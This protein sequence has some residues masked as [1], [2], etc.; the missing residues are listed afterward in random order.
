MAWLLV[1]ARYLA[2]G[3]DFSRHLHFVPISIILLSMTKEIPTPKELIAAAIRAGWRVRDG[4]KHVI[5]YPPDG[6]RPVVL[7]RQLKG[8]Q[9]PDQVKK[10]RAAG[11]SV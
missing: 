1:L 2:H 6:Q 8:R 5:I 10:C 11:L 9:I 4:G 3:Q 7:A